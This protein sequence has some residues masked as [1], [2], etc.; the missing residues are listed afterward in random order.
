MFCFNLNILYTYIYTH[1]NRLC[2]S[3]FVL[4]YVDASQRPR[5]AAQSSA[6]PVS[7][8]F[9]WQAS[10]GRSKPWLCPNTQPGD[11]LVWAPAG[12]L[13]C[14]GRGRRHSGHV[15]SQQCWRVGREVTV[16]CSEALMLYL[17][18][19]EGRVKIYFSIRNLPSVSGGWCMVFITAFVFIHSLFWW[20]YSMFF[21]HF[22]RVQV[23]SCG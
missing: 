15:G 14:G 13:C 11:W 22:L 21:I 12:V 23:G 1:T 9:P 19:C 6:V 8:V 2:F 5:P 17:I 10:R 3:F 7:L 4:C 18:Y 20:P 16:S